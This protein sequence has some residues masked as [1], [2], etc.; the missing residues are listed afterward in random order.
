MISLNLLKK[1]FHNQVETKIFK[2]LKTYF[3]SKVLKNDIYLIT[4]F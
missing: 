1:N 4:L 2:L 3:I